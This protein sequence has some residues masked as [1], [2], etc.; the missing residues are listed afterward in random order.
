M[1]IILN[2]GLIN[3]FF[4]LIDFESILLLDW[5]RDSR[6]S[7]SYLLMLLLLLF[8]LEVAS[9]ACKLQLSVRH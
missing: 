3:F 8:V 9:Q 2:C 7:H 5:T 6:I 1:A 4:C